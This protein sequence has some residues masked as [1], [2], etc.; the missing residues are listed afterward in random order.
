MCQMIRMFHAS[1][2]LQQLVDEEQRK[3]NLEEAV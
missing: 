3:L 2:A 1:L